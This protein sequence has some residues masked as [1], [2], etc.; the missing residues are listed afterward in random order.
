MVVRFVVVGF[1]AMVFWLWLAIP[2]CGCSTRV[3]AYNAAM[4]SDLKNLA[5]QQEIHFSD[6]GAY[7]RDPR[8]L[9]FTNSDGVFVDIRLHGTAGWSALASHAAYQ[10]RETGD[11]GNICVIYYGDVDEVPRTNVREL[12]PPDPG[13]IVCDYRRPF[14]VRRALGDLLFGWL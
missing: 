9:A 2:T 14:S 10:N 3:G 13:V 8:E 7:S 12:S 5:S 1:F 11:P 4:K 6:A